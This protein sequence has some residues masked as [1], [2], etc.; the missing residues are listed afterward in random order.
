MRTD[1][2]CKAF[3]NDIRIRNVPAGLA[4]QTPFRR[5]DGDAVGFY[6]I[7][8]SVNPT[9]ARLEDD[10]DTIPYLEACGVDLGTEARADAFNSLLNE[11]GA[12]YSADEGTLRTM[13]MPTDL[14]PSA[15]LRFVALL[16]RVRDLLLLTPERVASTFRDDAIAAIHKAFE[17]KA[18]VIL[19][20]PLSPE[21]ENYPAADVVVRNG[22]AAPMAIYLGTSE[23][24]VLEA[25][26][27]RM[28]TA[29]YAHIPCKVVLL[30]ERLRAHAIKESSI[31]RAMNRLDYVGTF[32]GTETDAMMR[33]QDEF[34]ARGAMLQ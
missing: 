23:V 4:V 11:Y 10:G 33:L 31:A 34:F 14:L 32:R 21:L 20:E 16:L 1:D 15:A 26:V 18:S 8:N 19:S 2:L 7:R 6:V 27:L 5:E 25:M 30:L 3:C 24:K 29:K 9:E 28:E 12:E 17:G 13:Y 22:S